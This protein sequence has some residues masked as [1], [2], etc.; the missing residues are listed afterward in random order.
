M[1]LL[2]SSVGQKDSDIYV[3][4]G[5]ARAACQIILDGLSFHQEP[6]HLGSTTIPGT[7]SG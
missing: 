2:H 5:Q 4:M 7:T 1:K 6:D 3:H